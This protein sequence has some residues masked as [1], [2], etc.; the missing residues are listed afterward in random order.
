LRKSF[1]DAGLADFAVT[2]IPRGTSDVASR[3]YVQASSSLYCA[4]CSIVNRAVGDV[5]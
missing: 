2:P 1:A 5:R 3:M 4:F